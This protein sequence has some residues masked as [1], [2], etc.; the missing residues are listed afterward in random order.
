MKHNTC[1]Y[2]IQY[3]NVL[4][5]FIVERKIFYCFL[6]HLKKELEVC[7]KN[8]IYIFKSQ[9]KSGQNSILHIIIFFLYCTYLWVC[10]VR[11]ELFLMFVLKIMYIHTYVE[12]NYLNYLLYVVCLHMIISV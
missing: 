6:K 3:K 12:C 9:E 7:S 2:E 8:G 11:G 4:Y 1:M 10:F 5:F